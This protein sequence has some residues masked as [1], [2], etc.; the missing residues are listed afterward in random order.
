MVD[1]AQIRFVPRRTGLCGVRNAWP[2]VGAVSNPDT[3]TKNFG[4][5]G[6]MRLQ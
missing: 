5:A 6:R 4:K 2:P 1:Y 3:P